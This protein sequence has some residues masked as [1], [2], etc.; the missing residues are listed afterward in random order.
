MY[1]SNTRLLSLLLGLAALTLCLLWL[2]SKQASLQ[3]PMALNAT[4]T[5]QLVAGQPDTHTPSSN[6][7]LAAQVPAPALT[8]AQEAA[9]KSATDPAQT[10]QVNTVTPPASEAKVEQSQTLAKATPVAA[11]PEIPELSEKEL[12]ALSAKDRKR[13]DKMLANLRS[14]RE[15]S[16]Q[17][18]SERQKL[19]QQ[20]AELEQRNQELAK[21]LEQVRATNE[22]A[23]KVTP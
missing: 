15:Q 5:T 1:L 16:T 3:N 13:Y 20:M 6:D 9:A 2:L 22:T 10:N 19:E 4:E 12:K 11:M 18:S 23:A 7:S 17:L 21:Q 14:I 8:P